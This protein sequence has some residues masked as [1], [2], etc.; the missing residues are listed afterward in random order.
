MISIKRHILAYL[1][2]A[3]IMSQSWKAVRAVSGTAAIAGTS[4]LFP[5]R[6]FHNES[7]KNVVGSKIVNCDCRKK[8]PPKKCLGD[9]YE[10]A[11]GIDFQD[12]ITIGVSPNKKTHV[13]MSAAPRCMQGMCW[14]PPARAYGLALYVRS[15]F[16]FKCIKMLQIN[17]VE[18]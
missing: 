15:F 12:R 11:L 17:V 16:D 6:R 9:F 3:C 14:F 2:T 18:M 13:L 8:A 5:Q 7:G 10:E 1:T 4:Y